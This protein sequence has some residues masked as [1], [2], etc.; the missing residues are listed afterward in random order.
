MCAHV[1]VCVAVLRTLT[2]ATCGGGDKKYLLYGGTSTSG[3]C[4]ATCPNACT[5]R[6]QTSCWCCQDMWPVF[7]GTAWVGYM[8][9]VSIT[10]AAGS[11][12]SSD[13]MMVHTNWGTTASTGETGTTASGQGASA[14]ICF[15]CTGDQQLDTA[16]VVRLQF[17]QILVSINQHATCRTTLCFCS[18]CSLSHAAIASLP[19]STY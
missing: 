14:G 9:K 10:L 4:G 1:C 13:T 19:N 16:T 8:A 18:L 6:T 5:T 11:T 2:S 12:V 17:A 7:D 15:D 3:S